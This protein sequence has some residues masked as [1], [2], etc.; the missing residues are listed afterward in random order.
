MPVIKAEANK[1]AER[2]VILDEQNTCHA[3]LVGVDEDQRCEVA[4]LSKFI[5]FSKIDDP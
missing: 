2:F 4:V 1:P 3:A 5:R